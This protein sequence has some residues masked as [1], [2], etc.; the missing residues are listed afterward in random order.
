MYR[1]MGDDLVAAFV[2]FM[3]FVPVVAFGAGYLV[4]WCLSR[5]LGF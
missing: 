3:I 4:A 1:G 2:A 5:W